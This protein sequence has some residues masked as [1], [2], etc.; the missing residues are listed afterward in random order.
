MW[1]FCKRLSNIKIEN[2]QK[3]AFKFL[4]ENSDNLLDI[5]SS[6]E[7]RRLRSLAIEIYKT[8]NNLN[9]RYTK[10]IFYKKNNRTSNRRA[11]NLEVNKFNSV[12]YGRNSLRS[13]GPLLW[14]S[15]P[16][17]VRSFNSLD[18]FKGF[19]KNWGKKDCPHYGKFISYYQ[20]VK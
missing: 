20:A 2:I 10:S 1:H 14:N 12:K 19:M 11:N 16:N 9:P 5:D 7:I 3:R 4:N 13:L 15:L 8:L 18:K 6:M 17:D